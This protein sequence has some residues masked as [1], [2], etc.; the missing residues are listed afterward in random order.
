MGDSYIAD[1]NAQVLRNHL[2]GNGVKAHPGVRDSG[3]NCGLALFIH[4]YPPGKHRSPL[5]TLPERYA[6]AEIGTGFRPAPVGGLGGSPQGFFTPHVQVLLPRPRRIAFLDNV[7][8][9]DFVWVQ[10]HFLGDHIDV[11]LYGEHCLRLSR[12]PVRPA[13]HVVGVDH[14]VVNLEVGDPVGSAADLP[15]AAEVG[16]APVAAV[17][18]A[19]EHHPR[20][21][22]PETPVLLHAC[23]DGYGGS[24][25]GVARHEFFYVGH[26]HLDGTA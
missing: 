3:R 9:P 7:L 19:V 14:V 15:S 24:V 13:R 17:S 4:A 26:N 10:P 6:S 1:R 12:R 16:L 20:L 23:L 2:T 8:E 11:G 5:G 18:A 22:G 21:A 25:P